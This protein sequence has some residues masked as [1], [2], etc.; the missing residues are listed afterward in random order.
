MV[1]YLAVIVVSC[2]F[3][4]L[5]GIPSRGEVHLVHFTPNFVTTFPVQVF[6]FTCAQNV[7]QY[8]LFWTVLL[9]LLFQLFPIYNELK[10]NSQA[11]M[12][13]MIGGSI[14]TATVVYEVIAVFGYL[15]FGSKVGGDSLCVSCALA[16]PFFF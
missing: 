14:G 11:R 10:N 15:T 12:N 1:A 8:F 4:P 3:W 7:G 6:A 5:K 13:A 2:Y 9:I 16:K